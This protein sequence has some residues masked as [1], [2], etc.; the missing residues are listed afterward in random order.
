MP[1]DTPSWHVHCRRLVY[2][3]LGLSLLVTI[4]DTVAASNAAVSLSNTGA[5]RDRLDVPRWL[6]L[7]TGGS[8][9]GASALLASVVTD[10]G[11]IE[12]IH[13]WRLSVP[14]RAGLKRSVIVVSQ[15]IGVIALGYIVW[16]GLVGPQV[17]TV[18]AAIILVFAG[19][20]AGLTMVTYLIGNPWP[21]LNPW[22]TIAEWLPTL[23]R[24]YPAS[25]GHW[26]AV[27]GFLVLVWIETT[28]AVNTLPRTLSLTLL[29]Y[30]GITLGGALVF[31]P[32]TWFQNVDPVSAFFRF[33]GAVSPIQWSDDGFRVQLH[34]FALPESDI[35]SGLDD[36]AFVIA[37]VWELTFTGFV[38]TTVGAAAVSILVRS[39]VPALA[40][41]A[42]IFVGGYAVFLGAYLVATRRSWRVAETYLSERTLALRFA[43]P[44]LAIAAGYHLAHYFAFFVSLSLP[45]IQVIQSPLS[46]PSNPLVL[47]LPWWFG[48]LNIAFVLVGH[49]LAIWLAHAIAYA[50]FPSRMQAIKSQYP[51]VIVMIGYTITSLWLISLPTASPAFLG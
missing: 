26:P 25:I 30:T 3:V 28:T 34:G 9:I 39:G 50:T 31:S 16:R 46:P 22:R 5:S 33:Y 23:D 24:S 18:N 12:G 10:R 45:V 6:Y 27:I 51:F 48:G 29:G 15:L 2:L 42:V 4:V 49:L 37:L 19:V 21:A 32:D 41:Y 11:F 35:V 14:T 44:L 43:L 13:D 20:R 47:T 17:P 40:V 7:L 36:V 1:A 8:T 38:T